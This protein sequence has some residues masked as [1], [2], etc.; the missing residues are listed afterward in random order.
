M[1]ELP[2]YVVALR[3]QDSS[4]ACYGFETNDRWQH[5]ASALGPRHAPS[6]GQHIRIT[7]ASSK[8]ESGC[9]QETKLV[10]ALNF[11]VNCIILEL[12]GGTLTVGVVF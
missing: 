7:E 3:N 10:E 1:R 4:P 12:A 6:Q 8:A 11:P 5:P 2:A 9:V